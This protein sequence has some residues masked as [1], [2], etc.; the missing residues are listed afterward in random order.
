MAQKDSKS[1]RLNPKLSINFS[2]Y[3]LPPLVVQTEKSLKNRNIVIQTLVEKQA[4]TTTC[5]YNIHATET[6]VMEHLGWP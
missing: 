2:S 4:K 5:T 1:Y 3:H 6:N